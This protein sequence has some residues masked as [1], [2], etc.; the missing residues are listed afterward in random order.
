MRIEIFPKYIENDTGRIQEIIDRCFLNGGGEIILNAG[1]YNVGGLRLRSDITLRL[2]SGAVLKGSRRAEDYDILDGDEIEPIDE[3]TP[4]K[5]E[6]GDIVIENCKCENADRFLH[7]NFSGNEI[8]QTNKPLG[9]ITFRNVTASGIDMPLNGY[10]DDESKY[11]LTIENCNFSFR[12]ECS[13]FLCAANYENINIKDTVIDNIN[14][15]AVLCYK[16]GG[17]VRF[18]NLTGVTPEIKFTEEIFSAESI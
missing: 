12:K 16:G 9:D 14:G 18:E 15:P 2:K 7:Y 11:T 10:G 13:E 6:P 8:W 17:S 5:Y 3:D 4:A 1:I